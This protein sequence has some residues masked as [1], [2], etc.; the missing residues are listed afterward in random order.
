MIIGVGIILIGLYVLVSTILPLPMV[1]TLLQYWP[2]TLTLL[3]MSIILISSSAR[4]IGGIVA[5]S[6]IIML[7]QRTTLFSINAERAFEGLVILF[8]GLLA[9][10]AFSGPK[11]HD[12]E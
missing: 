5:L 2:A 10:V 11:K 9:L 8:L 12:S 3:G 4:L 6:G 7:I 1:Q